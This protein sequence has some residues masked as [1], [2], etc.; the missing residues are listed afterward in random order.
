MADLIKKQGLDHKY[1]LD[2]CGTHG[3]HSGEK[4]D[5]R[6]RRIADKHGYTLT[7]IARKFE[8]QQDFDT[9]S[10]IVA[11]DNTHVEQLRQWAKNQ[12]Q[13]EKIIA[14]A[15]YCTQHQ[16]TDIPDPYYGDDSDFEQVINLL[17]DACAGLLNALE[18]APQK[19][20]EK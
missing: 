17:E 2:S 15:D 13:S 5:P 1:Q 9:A 20:T 4:A 11:M 8:V 7:S 12:T 16:A 6:M 3:L 10:H 14:M 18:N 19:N